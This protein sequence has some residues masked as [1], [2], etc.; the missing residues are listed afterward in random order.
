ML[1]IK[2]LKVIDEHQKTETDEDV[3]YFPSLYTMV[4]ADNADNE[5]YVEVDQKTYNVLS[6]LL[7]QLK[8][9]TGRVA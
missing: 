6:E 2:G 4:V 9:T 7:E 5:M 3:M 8:S 1:T